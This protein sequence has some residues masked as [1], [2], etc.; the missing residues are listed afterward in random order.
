[1]FT[2]RMVDLE[3]INILVGEATCMRNQELV[4]VVYFHTQL[5]ELLVVVAF[6]PC[7]VEEVEKQVEAFHKLEVVEQSK[8][9][10]GEIGKVVVE[11]STELVVRE[12]GRMVGVQCMA[13]EVVGIRVGVQCMEGEVVGSEVEVGNG[14]MEVVVEMLMEV[15]GNGGRL[16]VVEENGAVAEEEEGGRLEV[17]EESEVVVEENGVVVEEK[18]KMEGVEMEM[19]V[20]EMG[21][22]VVGEMVEEEMGMVVVVGEGSKPVLA[23]VEVVGEDSKPVLVEA[24]KEEVVVVEREMVEEEMA[25]VARVV[26]V[27]EEMAEEEMAE[28]VMVAVVKEVGVRAMVVVVTEVG[29]RAMVEVVRAVGVREVGVREMV[30][31]VK[32]VEV[33]A[34]VEEEVMVVVGKVV[35]EMGKSSEDYRRMQ[36]NLRQAETGTRNIVGVFSE[37]ACWG[38]NFS[39]H[40]R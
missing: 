1:M 5:V 17:V 12:R 9:E 20:V 10:A 35:G 13:G 31:V 40:Q 36:S 16:E 22:L 28:V 4:E 19:G 23:E 33:T 6:L 7:K 24:V 38:Y 27:E 15:E 14:N 39:C 11:Q 32:E 30:E 26:V 37:E 34:A 8:W 3:K 2:K 21:I 25:G 18:D 29:V